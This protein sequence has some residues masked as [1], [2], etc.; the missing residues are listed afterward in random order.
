MEK[1]GLFGRI[2]RKLFSDVYNQLN[3]AKRIVDLYSA[4]IDKQSIDGKELE[5]D[6]A[7]ILGNISNC[8]ITIKPQL[9][10]RVVLSEAHFGSVLGFS[11][12][13]GT[14]IINN[15]FQSEEAIEAWRETEED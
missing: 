1:I 7:A 3:S 10:T 6:N 4:L 9:H 15:I 14:A 13:Q 8:S 12:T 5:L 2:K 11:K